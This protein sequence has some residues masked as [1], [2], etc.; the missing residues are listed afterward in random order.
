[1]ATIKLKRIGYRAAALLINI[2][3][4]T[5]LRAQQLPREEWGAVPV[6]VSHS[7]TNWVIAGKT[8][9]VTLNETSLALTIQSGPVHWK[10]MPSQPGDML[11]RS[12][13]TPLSLRLADA[14]TILIVPYD[15]AF[16]TG[17]KISLSG[18][19]HDGPQLD[20]E[21]FLTICLEGR[22]EEVVF[23]LVA[24]ER[25]TTLRQLDWPGALDAHDVDY[26]LLSNGR[27]TLL[28]RNWP[29]QYYPI[30][31]L[32]PD[33]KI[34]PTDH[35]LLQSHVI[36]SWS[37]S[38][39]GFQKGTSGLMVIVE[40]PD[41]AAY[42]FSHPPGG[43]TVIGPRWRSQLGHFNYLRSAR[44]IP[45]TGG[46]YV[47]MAKR[48]RRYALDTGLFVSLKEKIARTPLLG[49]LVGVPH[50]RASILRNL[51]PES[52]RYDTKDPSKN[53]SL[54]TFEE[55]ARQLRELKAKGLERVLVFV[56]GWPHLGYDRQHPD[57]LPPPEQA[58]GWDGMKRLVDTCREIGYPVIFHDQYRDY[59][60]DAPSYNDQFAVQ[61][62][63]SSLPA[64]QFPGSRFGDSKQGNIPMM[65]HWDGGRQAYLNPRFQ[66]GHLRK[67]Y[68][69][70]FDRGIRT[71][72]IYID[73]I[74][75]VPPDQDFNPEHP[76]THTDAMRGQ[77]AML[78]WSRQNLGITATESGADW[79]IPYVD[80][81]NSSGGGSKAI[82]VPLY[83]LVYHDAVIVTF[84]AR[85]EK[86]LLQ[87]LLFG[88]VPEMPIDQAAVSE[89]TRALMRQMCVLHKRVGMLEMTRHEFLGNNYRKERTTFADGTTVTVDWDS[90]SYKIEP[91]SR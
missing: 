60:L 9:R 26:T 17:V 82:L 72:G 33:G 30:R 50:M 20:L 29:K 6:S 3:L 1:M 27:G 69:L 23:D 36:E 44:L 53:Y 11:V 83:N 65:R 31:S 38:W 88:G 49:D 78:N 15:A 14:K 56:S 22:N 48:Y 10:M 52:D 32:T 90:S 8:N 40:T 84:S 39:W 18:W 37:M 66:V 59:Y 43:P 42:Q 77:I 89:K 74:G 2:A 68:Q 57:S 51:K 34:A 54:T 12:K 85:D 81:I 55:R 58:G 91:E 64:Q 70:L 16:K 25:D 46:N 19:Q 63:D 87:G 61:E 62:K 79:T 76:T 4:S 7:G 21:L 75:Y 67:N 86:T 71:D 5:G 80:I 28:P 24:N 73:V 41:D 45:I 47:D 35:S 13:D